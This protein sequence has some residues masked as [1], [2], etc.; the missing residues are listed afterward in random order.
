MLLFLLDGELLVRAADRQNLPLLP[1]PPPRITRYEP[2]A[3]EK[4]KG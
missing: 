4:P 1:Q 3:G 2:E